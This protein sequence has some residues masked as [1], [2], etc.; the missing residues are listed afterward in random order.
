M[1]NTAIK[2]ILLLLI[3]SV[4]F[5]ISWDFV[6][7][8][9]DRRTGNPWEYRVDEYKKVSDASLI[10]YDEVLNIKLDSAAFHG[11]DFDKGN[12]YLIGSDF[13]QVISPDG[14]EI[15]HKEFPTTPRAFTVDSDRVFIVFSNHIAHFNGNGMQVSSWKMKDENNLITAIAAYGNNLFLADAA[16]RRIL[17]YTTSGEYLGMF[18]GKSEAGQVHGFIVPGGCFDLKVSIDGELWVVNPG[19]HALELY[20]NEGKLLRFWEKP[21]FTEEGFSGCCNPVHIAILPDGSFVTS[22]KG[23]V[24]IKIHKPYGDF[25]CYVAPPEQFKDAVYAPDLAVGNNG[26]I[27]ALDFNTNVIRVYSPL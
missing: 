27:Y 1:N 13:L 14:I 25:Q 5:I 20:S 15:F 9:P 11:I 19:K 22:E 17:R 18:E 4:I 24:R 21:S 3:I 7:K 10:G 6:M 16:N 8:R 12:I 2:I 23:I 26:M